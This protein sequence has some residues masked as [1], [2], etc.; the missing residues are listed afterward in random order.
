[1]AIVDVW[2]WEAESDLHL[3]IFE[4]LLSHPYYLLR[5]GWLHYPLSVLIGR[6]LRDVVMKFSLRSKSGSGLE[7]PVRL[8]RLA[9]QRQYERLVARQVAKGRRTVIV[10]DE[11]DRATTHMAQVAVTLTRRSLDQAGVAVV[12]SYVDG[13]MRYKAFNPLLREVLPDL[14]S[15]MEAVIFE[16][17]EADAGDGPLPDLKGALGAFLSHSYAD[18]DRLRREK[19]QLRFT[20]KYLGAKRISLSRVDPEAVA[21]MPFRFESLASYRPDLLVGSLS[22]E[23]AAL[24]ATRDLFITEAK[25]AIERWTKAMLRGYEVPPIR[26]LED[27]MG[28]ALRGLSKLWARNGAVRTPQDWAAV[29]VAVYDA[30]VL[31]WAYL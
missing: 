24:D 11:I 30:A 17:I 3:A 2:K 12:L 22:T 10:L 31:R 18:R 4:E 14:G 21:A 29:M 26:F 25:M 13:L 1:M 23:P 27:R 5:F 20:E 16:R 8:P 9:W 6:D 28:E 19:I 15:T 7:V